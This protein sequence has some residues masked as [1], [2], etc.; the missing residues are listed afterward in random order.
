MR[1]ITDFHIHSKWSRACSKQLTLPNIAKA[2][3]SKGIQLVGTSDAFH[4]AWRD[5]IGTLLQETEHG[6]FELKDGSSPT[7][8]LLTVEISSIYKRADKTRRVHNVIL[9]S[10][11]K[12]LDR[13][14]SA[15]NERGCNLKSDGRPIVGIDS[16]ELMKMTLDADPN[17]LLIP[18][19]AWTPW[20]A[21]FG[22]KSG[23][24]SIE[25]CFGEMSKYVYAIETG[26]SSDPKMNWRL[27]ALDNIFLVSNSDAHSLDK[28]GREAN[29]FEM[30][31]PSYKEL[32]RIIVEHDTKKFI[33]TLEFF[34][35]EGKYFVDGHRDCKFW[36]EPE[37]TKKLKGL[38]PNCG[39][40]LTIGVLHRVSD[41]AD[42]KPN[43]DKPKSAT[44]FRSIIPLAEVVSSVF[45]VGTKSK[46]VEHEIENLVSNNRTEF[47]ILL[48]LSEKEL[49]QI[50]SSEI[51]AAIIAMRKGDV[52][53]KPG[54]DGEFGVIKPRI[55]VEKMEQNNLFS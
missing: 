38:C 42:R 1:V 34:P 44:S 15:L 20:F 51:V 8:F 6:A 48:D 12:A 19:H 32:R 4:P 43:P 22:S 46:R 10:N 37:K 54:Y 25:E 45:G 17:N 39:K 33:E 3:E 14:T 29:V 36:C 21:I 47:G 41:L 55:N 53:L 31:Q 26:L 49:L 7:K 24:D 11:L 9:F 30:E 18:A 50:T 16:E 40:L 2:C 13:M 52:E 5:D 35:E 27:S 28:L 23:F